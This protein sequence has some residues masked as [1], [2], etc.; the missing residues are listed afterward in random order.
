MTPNK[1]RNIHPEIKK[2]I[3]KLKKDGRTLADIQSITGV[4][5]STQSRICVLE[6]ETGQV[7]RKAARTG[8]NPKLKEADYVVSGSMSGLGL[9]LTSVVPRGMHHSAARRAASRVAAHA[10]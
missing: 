3:V 7:E 2:L 1:R 8:R 10:E 9:P 5:K 6:R 4:A